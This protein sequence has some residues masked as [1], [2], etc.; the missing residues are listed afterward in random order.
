MESGANVVPVATNPDMTDLALLPPDERRELFR[1]AAGA[2]SGPRDPVM[3][4]KDYWVCWM[5]GC[6]FGISDV[7]DLV[8]GLVF[9][10][11]TSLSKVYGA[12]NRFSEDIDLTLPREA[13]GIGASDELTPGLSVT[14]ARRKLEAM[15][16]R[17]HAYVAAP[18]KR[19]INE[20]IAVGLAGA[21]HSQPWSL[22]V[23]AEDAG[24]LIFTYPAALEAGEYGVTSYVAPAVRLEFSVKNETSPAHE[25]EVVPY[26]N[27][28]TPSDLQTK[29][30]RVRVLHGERTFWEKATILHLEAHRGQVRTGA[31]RLSR[32]YADVAMLTE[33]DIGRKA[34]DQLDLLRRVAQHK[35][36]YFRTPWAHY[37]DAA[38]GRLRLVPPPDLEAALRS[39]YAR[40]REMYFVQPLPFDDILDRLRRLEDAV[41]T[42]TE[43]AS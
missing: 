5:L 13:L 33:H 14:K 17:C 2:D 8:P 29:P 11:G 10:G 24:S 7:D 43:A 15:A 36:A 6:L 30:I 39:D 42:R 21:E 19:A 12:I 9:K 3:I 35:A 25:G 1:R 31:D 4:E 37:D 41:R 18:L 34:L 38:A 27:A 32:H 20:R 28:A 26:A 23:A 22:D 40:M 16:E